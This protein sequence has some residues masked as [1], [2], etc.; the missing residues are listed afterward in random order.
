MAPFRKLLPYLTFTILI[1]CSSF[2]AGTSDQKGT[3]SWYGKQFHGKKTASGEI[4][5][6]QDLTAAHPRL[7]FGTMV[8]V[9]SLTSGRSVRVRINDRGPF[10]SNR[11]IDLSQAA[12][13]H[14][15][16]IHQGEDQVELFID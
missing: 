10:H 12:A 11:I 9:R 13:A 16:I 2:I 15:G 6:S 1:S 14:L 7:P 4:F 8:L 3:A 5:N